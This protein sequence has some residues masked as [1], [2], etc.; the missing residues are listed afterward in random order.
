MNQTFGCPQSA[1]T[2]NYTDKEIDS[3]LKYKHYINGWAALLVIPIG[4]VANLITVYTLLHPKMRQSSTNTYLCALSSSNAVS[5]VCLFL[6]N[7]LR[8]TIVHPYRS[9]FCFSSYESFINRTLPYLT[10]INQTFQLISIYLMIAVSIDRYVIVVSKMINSIRRRYLTFFA[11]LL[12]SLFSF[13]ITLPNWYF[14]QSKQ[15]FLNNTTSFYIASYTEFGEKP[16]VKITHLYIYSAL[17]FGLPIFVLIIINSLIIYELVKISQRK[18]KLKINA[19]IDRNITYM[20]IG[21]VFVFLLCQLPLAISHFILAH[22]PSMS[23]HR[24]FFIYNSFTNFSTCI[25][26][27]SN[28]ILFCFFGQKFRNT[29]KLILCGRAYYKKGEM[30]E[31]KNLV[32]NNNNDNNFV[33]VST[34][35]DENH[36]QASSFSF[37]KSD[38]LKT[39]SQNNNIY[40]KTEL[41]LDELNNLA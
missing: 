30:N 37:K 29:L 12:I 26:M 34:Y 3:L 15:I 19:N 33:N 13:L 18:K 22:T 41:E 24:E 6:T 7:A 20:L 1:N 36:N 40:D 16:L 28:F 9:E 31:I 39:S 25:Y 23:Q 14:Y 5:L 4:I 27:S 8:F 17:V 32:N 2:Y 10:P 35:V 38:F 11:I 21:I